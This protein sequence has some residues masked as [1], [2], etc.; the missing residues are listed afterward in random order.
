M[1][2]AIISVARSS[3]TGATNGADTIHLT[4][5]VAGKAIESDKLLEVRNPYNNRMVGTVKQANASHVKQ[6]IEAALK[7]GQKLTRYEQR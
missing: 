5:Y 7:G 4:G 6:A 3:K 1:S 2:N